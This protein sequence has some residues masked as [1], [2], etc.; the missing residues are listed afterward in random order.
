MISGPIKPSL[1]TSKCFLMKLLC[2]GLNT[3]TQKDSV[4][5]VYRALCL[6]ILWNTQS[7]QRVWSFPGQ[8][9]VRGGVK[10]CVHAQ[11]HSSQKNTNFYR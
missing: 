7:R 11:W 1:E 10:W 6:H 2:V 8:F 3:L 9:Q 4:G 5:I